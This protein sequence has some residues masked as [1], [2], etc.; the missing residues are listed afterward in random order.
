[1]SSTS[2]VPIPPIVSSPTFLMHIDTKYFT[3]KVL[4][5][6]C[7]SKFSQ[8]D[9]II[10]IWIPLCMGFIHFAPLLKTVTMEIH[11]GVLYSNDI[12][13]YGLSHIIVLMFFVKSIEAF[14]S[15]W[16]NVHA[17]LNDVTEKLRRGIVSND[18]K[19]KYIHA[20]FLVQKGWD[21]WLK[22]PD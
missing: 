10:L 4:R 18:A 19:Y 21:A 15:V 9:Y 22:V 3:R 14:A 8:A 12:Y 1:M 7:K 5:V 2:P 11:S 13:K 16:I 20:C 6:V 17:V